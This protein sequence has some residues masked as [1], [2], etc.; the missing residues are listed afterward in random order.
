MKHCNKCN[1]DKSP[2]AFYKSKKARDGL[3]SWC[4][5]CCREYHKSEHYIEIRNKYHKSEVG[6]ASRKKYTQ[7]DKYRFIRKRNHIK[8][9]YNIDVKDIPDE[10]QICSSRTR[11]SVD[12]CHTTGKVRGF[13][14]QNCNA[15]LG[16]AKDDVSRLQKLIDY[17]NQNGEVNVSN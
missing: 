7:S 8:R 9:N 6:K 16:M 3:H 12:H 17:L 1:T 2:N 14:C 11:I 13:L 10:C 5:E 4:K 15:T